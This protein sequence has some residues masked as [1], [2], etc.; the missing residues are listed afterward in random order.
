MSAGQRN[1]AHRVRRDGGALAA[2]GRPGDRRCRAVGVRA[3]F[4]AAVPESVAAMVGAVLLFI[5]PLHWRARQFTL[6]WEEAVRIDWGII[7]LFG[8]GLAMGE[9]AFS[10]GLAEAMGRGITSWLP[11]QSEVVAH[12][13]LHGRRDRDVGSGVEHRV[14]QHDRA[15]CDRG[16][17]GRGRQPAA[18]GARRHARRV[19]GLHDADLHAARTRSST[20]RGTCRSPR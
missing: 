3:G 11:V 18:A 17:A 10:T 4:N 9:L 2:A 20:A 5:L 7:L 12:D 13:P 8:G 6:K 19:D 14:G 1:V 15:D 16:V